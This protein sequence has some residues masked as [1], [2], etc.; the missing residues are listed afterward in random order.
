MTKFKL[1]AKSLNDV[2]E[3]ISFYKISICKIE[4]NGESPGSNIEFET[5]LLI[6]KMMEGIYKI[7]D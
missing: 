4:R 6:D 3:L 5:E 2:I 7:T 1:R